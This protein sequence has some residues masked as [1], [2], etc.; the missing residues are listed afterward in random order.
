MPVLANSMCNEQEEN[1]L[2]LVLHCQS[3]EDM[4][5]SH[6]LCLM[7]LPASSVQDV[8]AALEDLHSS[9]CLVSQ[10]WYPSRDGSWS[11]DVQFRM[12]CNCCH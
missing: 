2:K 10:M 9:V 3:S 7:Q 6:T 12:L 8:H 5:H 4:M 1:C 11:T